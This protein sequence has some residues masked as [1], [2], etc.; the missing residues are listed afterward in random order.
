MKQFE[1]TKMESGLTFAADKRKPTKL[2]KSENND[3]VVRAFSYAFNIDYDRAHKFIET[4]FNRKPRKGNFDTANK[5]RNLKNAFGK[6]ITE[7]GTKIIN[8]K[9]ITYFERKRKKARKRLRQYTTESFIKNW[10]EGTYFILVR[11]HAF[12]IKDGVVYGNRTDGI[13]KLK[14]IKQAFLITQTPK[15]KTTKITKK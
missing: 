11:K 2:E 8:G 5:M 12:C 15:K 3:C 14:R 10:P 4:K 7:V 13:K 1:M 6:S 9:P